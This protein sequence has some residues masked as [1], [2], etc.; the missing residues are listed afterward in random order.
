MDEGCL[1]GKLYTL[2]SQALM[3]VGL[4]GGGKFV[5][6]SDVDNVTDPTPPVTIADK[7]HRW[8]S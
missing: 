3:V 5:D 1:C 4:F 2:T 8:P 7:V 6:N